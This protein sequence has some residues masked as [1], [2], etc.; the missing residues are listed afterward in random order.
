[1]NLNNLLLLTTLTR[2]LD[3]YHNKNKLI[4]LISSVY[5]SPRPVGPLGGEGL[6]LD[7]SRLAKYSHSNYSYVLLINSLDLSILKSLDLS[8]IVLDDPVVKIYNDKVV[9]IELSML[10]LLV[11]YLK[12]NYA[13]EN[14]FEEF[15]YD[16]LVYFS[17]SNE[18]LNKENILKHILFIFKDTE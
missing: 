8:N 5:Y 7:F 2:S 10:W 1:M 17:P 12:S 11:S 18:D 14:K 3:N 6:E 16:L 4:H 15:I 9:T 13:P